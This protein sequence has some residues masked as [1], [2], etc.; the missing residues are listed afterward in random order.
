M[1]GRSAARNVHVKSGESTTRVSQ[2]TINQHPQKV[3]G[4][5]L[6]YSARRDPYTKNAE[7]AERTAL[8]WTSG[9]MTL[10]RAADLIDRFAAQKRHHVKACLELADRPDSISNRSD[11]KRPSG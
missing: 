11:G 2:S 1:F 3:R 9:R 4:D 6:N 8:S 5:G 7:I 10:N